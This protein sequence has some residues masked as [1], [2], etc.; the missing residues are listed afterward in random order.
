MIK[1]SLI[2]DSNDNGK[3]A[4][5]IDTEKWILQEKK[6]PQNKTKLTRKKPDK[7]HKEKNTQYCHKI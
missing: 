4:R 5:I 3:S 1:L 2:P 6:N 7:K